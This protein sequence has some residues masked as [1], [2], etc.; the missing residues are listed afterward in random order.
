VHHRAMQDTDDADCMMGRLE[1]GYAIIT[2]ICSD[3]SGA[4]GSAAARG[5]MQR[6]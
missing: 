6:R 1:E 2:R 4:A 3:Y 5:C